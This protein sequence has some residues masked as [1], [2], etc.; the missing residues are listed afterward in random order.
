MP[1]LAQSEAVVGLEVDRRAGDQRQPLVRGRTGAGSRTAPCAPTPP[2]P[3]TAGGPAATA[4][5][6][7]GFG[8]YVREIETVLVSLISFASLRASSIGLTSDLKALREGC[9]RRGPRACV[10][11]CGGRSFGRHPRLSPA[12]RP[13]AATTVTS[14]RMPPAK[15]PARGSC[16]MI[17]ARADQRGG[18]PGRPDAAAENVERQRR[19]AH[20]E[21]HQRGEGGPHHERQQGGAREQRHEGRR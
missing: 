12:P 8:T 7:S 18:Q 10:P 21:R 20:E 9:P 11:G 15:A 5:P 14:A 2:N 3:R 6:C 16:G 4:T 1:E 13:A 17:G 19:A